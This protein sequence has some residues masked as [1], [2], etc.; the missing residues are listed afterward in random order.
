MG[1][2]QIKEEVVV[3]THRTGWLWHHTT[4]Q[5]LTSASGILERDENCSYH[6]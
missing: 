5:G 3:I 1:E 4:G 6:G 2:M